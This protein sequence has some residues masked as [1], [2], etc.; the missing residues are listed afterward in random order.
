M[1]DSIWSDHEIRGGQ[2]DDPKNSISVRLPFPGNIITPPP[3]F[4]LFFKGKKE[5]PFS[6]LPD[7]SEG[8]ELTSAWPMWVPTERKTL[9]PVGLNPFL[10]LGKRKGKAGGRGHRNQPKHLADFWCLYLAPLSSVGPASFRTVQ[11]TV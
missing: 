11:E 8:S 3:D 4:I 9:S 5:A 6:D 7:P 1:S 10:Q 2:Q